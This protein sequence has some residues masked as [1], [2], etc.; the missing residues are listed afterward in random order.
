MHYL[1]CPN[2]GAIIEFN[3]ED[4]EVNCHSCKRSFII[5]RNI[6]RNMEIEYKLVNRE[7]DNNIELTPIIKIVIILIAIIVIT[8]IIITLNL[9]S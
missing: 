2:C 4:Y 1:T 3:D 7:I 9:E 8:T 5:E 6:P